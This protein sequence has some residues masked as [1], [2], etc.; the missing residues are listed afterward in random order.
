MTQGKS[1]GTDLGSEVCMTPSLEMSPR[2]ASVRPLCT[3][4]AAF[5]QR[6]QIFCA[7]SDEPVFK[8]A[9][10]PADT[11]SESLSRTLAPRL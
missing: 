5:V 8:K 10:V 4:A 9:V 6:H 1:A 7:T 3:S 11:G 2:T